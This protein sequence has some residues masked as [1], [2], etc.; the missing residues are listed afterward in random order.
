MIHTRQLIRQSSQRSRRED[1]QSHMGY[2]LSKKGGKRLQYETSTRQSNMDVEQ[3]CIRQERLFS[4]IDMIEFPKWK[5]PMI[6]SL[7]MWADMA[8]IGSV[9]AAMQQQ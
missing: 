1:H 8:K 2:N 9:L 7:K 4:K 3:A 6:G 5:N